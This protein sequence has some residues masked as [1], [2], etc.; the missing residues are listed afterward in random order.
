MKDV[1]D[2]SIQRIN[3]QFQAMISRLPTRALSIFVVVILAG[4][5]GTF[6]LMSSHAAT[7]VSSVEPES[8]TLASGATQVSTTTASGGGAVKFNAAGGTGTC[9]TSTP[10]VPDGPDGMGGCWPGPSN[11][12]PNAPE[13][14]MTTYTGSC[15]INAAN[16]TIDSKIINCSPLT[17]GSSATGLIIKNSYLKGGIDQNGSAGFTLQDSMI[18]NARS[19][20]ACAAGSSCSAGLY[21]CGDIN[22][23]TADCGLNGSNFTVLRTEIIHMN[24]AAYCEST[25]TIQDSYFHGTNLWPSS[26][27][28]AHASSVRNENYLTLRHSAIG[29]DYNGPY[30]NDEIGC[31]ADLTGY[32]DFAPIHHATIDGN[33][34]LANPGNGFCAYGGGT[35]GKPYSNNAMNATY[36]VF[37]N[38]V[39]QRGTT[40]KCGS[41]GA[42]TDYISG[43]TG[44]VWSNNKYDNGTTVP[45]N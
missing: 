26:T 18:D 30:P 34:F 41:Y 20:P 5:I 3:R 8:G 25:C 39:F 38:N 10:H 37:Q 44:N 19:F 29:C 33:L 24:R 28:L 14:S 6:L 12:G 17:V 23:A 31:S 27:N 1:T 43:R 35:S 2:S 40:G 11:T 32:P 15:T 7:P 21:A 13:S 16:V 9:A 4:S 45:S 42:I 22:N 36:M